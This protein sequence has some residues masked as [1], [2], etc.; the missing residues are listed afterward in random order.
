MGHQLLSRAWS[1]P[2]PFLPVC[3]SSYVFRWCST[4]VTVCGSL[5]RSRNQ[6]FHQ[7]A[8]RWQDI[9]IVA[10]RGRARRCGKDGRSNPRRRH[11][12]PSHCSGRRRSDQH[13]FGHAGRRGAESSATKPTRPPA[14]FNGDGY[15]DLAVSKRDSSTGLVQVFYG[16]PT[17]FTATA[18]RQWGPQSFGAD[19]STGFGSALVTG[20]FDGDSYS[21]LAIGD[22]LW[23]PV[24]GGGG[25]VVVMYG[26]ASG[27]SADRVQQWSQ[28]S[29]GVR[30]RPDSKDQ[31][32][33]TLAAGNFGRGSQD[34][35]AIGVPGENGVGAA[36]ILYGA[37]AGLSSTGSQFWRLSSPGIPG[38]ARTGQLFGRALV[39]GDFN[40]GYDE[41]AIGVPSSS[42]TGSSGSV[43]VLRGS[44]TG[45]TTQGVQRW[46]SGRD[47][48]KGET[49]EHWF[50]DTLAVGR[51]SGTGHLDLVIGNPNADLVDTGSAGVVHVLRGTPNGLTATGDQL[52]SEYILGTRRECH[53]EPAEHPQFGATLLAANFGRGSS[54]D[55]VVGVP[56]ALA[57]GL[58][59]GAVSVIYGTA[60]GLR[61][62]HT[63]QLSQ[64][65]RGV[66]GNDP[67][68]AGF[69]S[70][71][72]L[73]GPFSDGH[74]PT[75]VI[76][77]P[78]Y[79]PDSDSPS[80]PGLV[81]LIHGSSDGLTVAGD[82]VLQARN[83]S[84]RPVGTNFGSQ[85]AR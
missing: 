14:D 72:A 15:R 40:G 56:G 70:A 17:G 32:G 60:S 30:G 75:L 54:D 62:T 63:Q 12:S 4:R 79:E 58:D 11:F 61:K 69:G 1:L 41:L 23:D 33:Q 50:G 5:A 51:F 55:L 57:P 45:L 21:D 8:A 82:Q 78:Y 52:W 13:V 65:T 20:D 22:P 18:S 84:P 28:S 42:D 26:S 68:G 81:N 64:A 80:E 35:L 46:R 37:P 44:A 25:Y 73:A 48:V 67:D 6:S 9:L 71:L 83:F 16:S 19:I 53:C 10:R 2:G 39:A 85:L 74:Y 31:F 24:E 77:A 49:G 76:G 47:G 36:Q 59:S 43:L 27:L 29:H 34:D 38:K 3:T 7:S 66:R